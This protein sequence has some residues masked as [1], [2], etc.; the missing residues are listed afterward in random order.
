MK[1]SLTMLALV[2]SSLSLALQ[3]RGQKPVPPLEK[4]GSERE[5]GETQ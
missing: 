2:I 5:F 3:L 4:F 1:T